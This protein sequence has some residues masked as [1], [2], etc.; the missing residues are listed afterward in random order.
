M[1]VNLSPDP[2]QHFVDNFGNALNGGQ[3]FTYAAGTTTKLA[4]YT[5][6]TGATTNTNPVVLNTRGEASVWL[7]PNL[8]Y[9]L[10]L[11]PSTDSDPPL[12][13]IW[14]IDNVQNP[15][16]AIS[17]AMQPV[18]QASSVS[19]A[20]ALMD[21]VP[22]FTNIA[23]LRA[24]AVP[25]LFVAVVLTYSVEGDNGGGIFQLNPADTTSPD[26]GGTIVVDTV[27]GRWYRIT[28]GQK[29]DVRWWGAKLDG[30]TDDTN[31][32][33]SAIAAASAA[34]VTLRH[35]GGTSIYTGAMALPDHISLEGV[36]SYYQTPGQAITQDSL[37]K[38]NGNGAG[39][40]LADSNGG[41][42][43][44]EKIGFVAG[45]GSNQTGFLMSDGLR[46]TQS[47]GWPTLRDVLFSGFNIGISIGNTYQSGWMYNVY[48]LNSVTNGY[49]NEATDWYHYMVTCGEN[50]GAATGAQLTLGPNNGTSPA[51]SSGNHQFH[52]GAFFGATNTVVIGGSADNYFEGAYIQ[53]GTQN[54][55][56]IQA[57]GAYADRNIFVACT[58]NGNNI[59]G[60]VRNANNTSYSDVNIGAFTRN[61]V[62]I[63]CN[64]AVPGLPAASAPC[65]AAAFILANGTDGTEIIGGVINMDAVVVPSSGGSP[66]TGI[67][68]NQT[69]QQN[70]PDNI[71][72][73]SVMRAFGE[74]SVHSLS[75]LL[76][77]MAGLVNPYTNVASGD[78]I[79]ITAGTCIIAPPSG[80]ISLFLPPPVQAGISLSIFANIGNNNVVA[81]TAGTIQ[82][83]SNAQFSSPGAYLDLVSVSATSWGIRASNGISFS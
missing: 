24:N 83:H 3:L 50:T 5:D 6:S 4:T 27:S 26:N 20:L 52:G 54:G 22:F 55:L 25:G 23:S 62:F 68:W 14:T 12:Q 57:N 2:I 21:G 18:V 38:F 81:A 19:T 75:Y 49:I 47:E 80:N 61:N 30:V 48:V 11:S 31:A 60:G 78:A 1:T 7:N 32:W 73:R 46:V 39:I 35:P 10:I 42:L 28:S 77:D 16:I 72:V 8:L 41:A 43:T 13:P 71:L 65:V 36:G 9:K 29:Y 37:I 69:M 17:A 66:G 44:I 70:T 51:F 33:N 64:Y 63:G 82:G 76:L 15:A 67:I 56:L 79:S 74:Q 45:T 53:N 59:A 40:T 34:R 58:F